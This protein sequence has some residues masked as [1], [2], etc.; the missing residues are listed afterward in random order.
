M[1]LPATAHRSPARATRALGQYGERLAERYLRDRGLMILDRNWR[2]V[3]GEIDIVALDEECL[4]FVE[5]KTRTTQAFGAP[6]EAVTRL[7][8]ARLRLLS[9]LWREAADVQ[10]RGRPSRI[11]VVS[12]LRPRSGPARIEHL[13]AVQ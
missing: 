7:K 9:G 5:V 1:N 2:C 12:I 8:L 13:R 11:D 3:R 4:V 10:W 6:F